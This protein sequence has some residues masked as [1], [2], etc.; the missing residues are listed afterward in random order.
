VTGC[1]VGTGVGSGV[2][3]CPVGRGVGS[4]VTGCPVAVEESD[5]E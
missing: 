4:G 5:P 3:G 1:P 2:T